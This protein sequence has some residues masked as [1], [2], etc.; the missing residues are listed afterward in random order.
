MIEQFQWLSTGYC[1]ALERVARRDGQFRHIQFPAPFGVLHHRTQGIVLFDTGYSPRFFEATRHFPY[2]MY[3]YAT[4]VFTRPEASAKAQLERQQIDPA[5]VRHILLSHFH[6]DH[7]CGLRDFPNAQFYCHEEAL[8]QLNTHT[9][10]QAARKGLLPDLFPADFRER[11]HV[12]TADNALPDPIFGSVWD[13]FGDGSITMPWLPGH[14]KGQ[15]GAR[16]DCAGQSWFLTADAA[17]FAAAIR[18]NILPSALVRLFF[19]DWKA[20]QQTLAK[21]QLYASHHPTTRMIPSHCQ[22]SFEQVQ[23]NS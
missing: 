22:D 19:D 18:H 4:P 15:I 12:F 16:F 8:E 14:G 23:Q 7:V 20:Y 2:R 17:W 1:T 5:E 10:F 13:V 3:R 6:G 11:C 9:G 21:L